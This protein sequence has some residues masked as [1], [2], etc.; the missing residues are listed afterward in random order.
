MA[1]GFDYGLDSS[2][3]ELAL[4]D[5]LIHVIPVGNS[6]VARTIRKQK[7]MNRLLNVRVADRQ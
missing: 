6:N 5:N 4:R 2:V 7:L 3:E 1:D